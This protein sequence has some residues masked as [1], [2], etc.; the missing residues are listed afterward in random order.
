MVEGMSRWNACLVVATKINNHVT[1]EA[2]SERLG[3]NVL[4][5]NHHA[6]EIGSWTQV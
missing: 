3:D 5:E 1:R 6:P 2:L 4:I